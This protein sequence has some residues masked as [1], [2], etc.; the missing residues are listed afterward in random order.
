MMHKVIYMGFYMNSKGVVGMKK[1]M[2]IVILLFMISGIRAED[3]NNSSTKLPIPSAI[4]KSIKQTFGNDY[5]I[6]RIPV[7]SDIYLRQ[8]ITSYNAH[9]KHAVIDWLKKELVKGSADLK[10]LYY[11]LSHLDSVTTAKAA[12]I[13]L[14]RAVSAYQTMRQ[15]HPSYQADKAWQERAYTIIVLHASVILVTIAR[16]QLLLILDEIYNSLTY[17]REQKRS[18]VKYFF[19]KSPL[20]W[21]MG[22]RQ[23]E[24]ISSNIKKLEKLEYDVRVVLGRLTKHIY[25]FNIQ[26]GVNESYFWIEELLSMLKCVGANKEKAVEKPTR[27]ENIVDGLRL[28]LGCVSVLKDTLMTKMSGTIKP[29]HFARNWISYSIAALAAY[30]ARNFHINNPDLIKGAAV[31]VG[32][33]VSDVWKTAADPLKKAWDTLVGNYTVAVTPEEQMAF[34][35]HAKEIENVVPSLI[36]KRDILVKSFGEGP[37]MKESAEQELKDLLSSGRGTW[38]LWGGWGENI[39][40]DVKKGDLTS[41][42]QAVKDTS[43]LTNPRLSLT[44]HKILGQLKAAVPV[45]ATLGLVSDIAQLLPPI[46]SSTQMTINYMG[47]MQNK[48]GNSIELNMRLLALIPV[49][50]IGGGIGALYYAMT[51]RDLSSVRLALLDINSLFIESQKPLTD[52][53][54]GKLIY[55][56]QGLKSEAMRYLTED[57]MRS[58]FLTDLAKLESNKFDVET[59]RSI[60]QNMFMKY[61]FLTLNAKSA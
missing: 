57:D 14:A 33:S 37:S 6:D 16:A 39:I 8:V 60:I 17:W 28:K 35:Q 44:L 24:E 38:Q 55:L 9:M 34:A 61:P 36:E 51:Q 42:E 40:E 48:Y 11:L 3:T 10:E 46:V 52:H 43:V 2:V 15:S 20:K 23:A 12:I 19:H 29:G 1:S 32:E 7:E 31:R 30:Q 27:F 21:V 53:D 5:K 41:L 25:A 22:K 49:T 45:Q 58:D 50:L 59:K 4:Q 13:M 26:G 56:L 18:P 47:M 54:Y